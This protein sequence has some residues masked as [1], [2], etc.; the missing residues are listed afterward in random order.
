MIEI[1]SSGPT[2]VEIVAP[3]K[4][5]IGGEDCDTVHMVLRRTSPY[6]EIYLTDP[7]GQQKLW[8][9]MNYSD[10]IDAGRIIKGYSI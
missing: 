4:P 8:F 9:T 7:S 10:F 1:R 3:S 5:M 2:F 6:M